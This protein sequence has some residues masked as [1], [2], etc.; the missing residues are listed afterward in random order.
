MS[1]ERPGGSVL[2]MS[3]VVTLAGLLVIAGVLAFVWVLAA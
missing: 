3:V 2:L 1:A